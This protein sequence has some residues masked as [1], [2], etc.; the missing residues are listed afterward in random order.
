MRQ[1]YEIGKNITMVM[2]VI[3]A[4]MLLCAVILA[5]TADVSLYSTTMCAAAGVSLMLSSF[6]LSLLIY[7][8]EDVANIAARIAKDDVTVSPDPDST[9]P[10]LIASGDDPNLLNLIGKIEAKTQDKA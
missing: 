7:L 6:A 2:L 8:G 10:K 9:I 3:G 1:I 4:L 5:T